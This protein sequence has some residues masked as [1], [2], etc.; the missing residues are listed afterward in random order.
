MKGAKK[1][2]AS[3]A[4]AKRQDTSGKLRRKGR[5]KPLI[6]EQQTELEVLAALPEEE[7]D[8]RDMP[9]VRDWTGA[10]RGVLLSAGEAADPVAR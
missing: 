7:I 2:G 3:S 6:P 10:R 8:T 4:R 1:S 5:S 9:E